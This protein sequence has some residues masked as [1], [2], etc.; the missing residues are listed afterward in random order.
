ML[1]KVVRRLLAVFIR[2]FIMHPVI[3]LV[4]LVA[5]VGIVGVGV[6]GVDSAQ[7]MRT[8]TVTPQTAPAAAAVPARTSVS[9][10]NA[11]P[12]APA[13]AVDQYIHGMISFDARLMWESL[14]PT[15][16]DAMTKQGG[17]EQSLQQRLDDAKQ[18][19]W[20]YEDV[21]YVGGYPLRNGDKYLFYVVSRRG[22]AGPG[23]VD[24]VFFVF[25][26]GP[27]GKILKIE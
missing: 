19:G 20:S 11:A 17:S 5:A 7:L 22:F 27:S 2:G 13:Q 26:V 12:V 23:I 3:G 15:A 24:Q 6:G 8:G 21:T 18:N 1:W 16:I 25:T 4:V 10:Q 14:D 9:F